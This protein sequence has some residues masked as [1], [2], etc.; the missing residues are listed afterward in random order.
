MNER[1]A[2][3]VVHPARPFFLNS[4][5]LVGSS[6]PLLQHLPRLP[7]V[8]DDV[9]ELLEEDLVRVEEKFDQLHRTFVRL[10]A[11]L[12]AIPRIASSTSAIVGSSS[13]GV[14][15]SRC[16]SHS[17]TSGSRAGDLVSRNVRNHLDH[18][19][20]LREG[21][22]SLRRARKSRRGLWSALSS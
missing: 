1:D 4:T 7:H 22:S 9:V 3:V 18:R 11:C 20:S 6:L 10:T 13:S 15:V 2:S 21:D 16:S 19:W 17:T 12:L 14:D 5:L 8:D